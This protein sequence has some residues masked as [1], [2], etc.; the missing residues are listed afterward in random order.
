MRQNPGHV[1]AEWDEDL[2]LQLTMLFRQEKDTRPNFIVE[3]GTYRGE[4]TTAQ[5]IEA[6][7]RAFKKTPYRPRFITIETDETN[8]NIA[9]ANLAD[10]K[11]V[12]VIHGSS[13]PVE[14]AVAFVQSD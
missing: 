14:E 8:Y 5:I 6:A 12:T 10:R 4:G 7:G 2:I 13:V 11:W 1:Q 9:K 3:T